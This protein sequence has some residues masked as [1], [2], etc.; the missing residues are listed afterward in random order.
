MAKGS[1]AHK[2]EKR[3]PMPLQAG[4]SRKVIEANI[5]ELVASG[6]PPK[7]AVAIALST[8]RK[9]KHMHSPD[10]FED[11]A[12]Q[13]A[14]PPRIEYH[15]QP[16]NLNTAEHPKIAGLSRGK[17]QESMGTDSPRA[18]SRTRSSGLPDVPAGDDSAIPSGVESYND[19]GE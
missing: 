19:T 6:R 11:A 15:R 1:R 10:R 16:E 5:H 8:A 17:I 9:A 2:E 4:K 14:E 18:N 7:Q 3:D 13:S 12:V